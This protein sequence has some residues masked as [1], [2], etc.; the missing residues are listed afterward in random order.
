MESA[1]RRSRAWILL[2][3]GVGTFMSAL[4]SSIVNVVLPVIRAETGAGI[5]AVQWTVTTYLLAVSGAL[6]GFGR[7]GDLQGHKRVYLWGFWVFVGGSLLCGVAPTVALLAAARA[8]QGIGAAVLFANSPAIVT[9]NFPAARR[10]Q[11]LGLIA[12]ATYLGL[13]VGPPLGG[14]LADT[15]TWRAVFFINVPVGAL[16][17]AIGVHFIPD[18]PPRSTGER[19]DIAGAALFTAGLVAL[20]LGLNQAHALG[21]GSPPI[22]GLLGLAAALL[23]AFL[24]WE[25]R[26][27][28]PMLDLRLFRDRVFSASTSGALLNYVAVYTLVFL[29]PFYLIQGR[30]LSASAAGA[31]LM[32][33]PAVMAVTAP[34]AGSL[35]DRVGSR[36]LATVGMTI[37]AVGLVALATLPP[38]VSLVAVA[39]TLAVVG[40]GTGTF[41]SP[42]NSALMGAAPR[43]RQGVAAAVL[44]EARNVGMVLGVGMAGA[45]FTTFLPRTPGAA[46]YITA[47]SAAL[48]AAAAA[49]ALSAAVSAIA[50]ARGARAG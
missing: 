12:T 37:M 43:H 45:I 13:T 4:D 24:W 50:G 5:A 11:A 49:A 22:L 28:Y 9:T 34:L 21:W 15:L 25:W 36:L 10:G 1:D 40:L 17:L 47:A 6:L 38:S 48:Y 30:G 8:M 18:D 29:M 7:L 42:N 46:D 33:Q 23:A 41:I 3:V 31:L 16:A 39:A 19:F 32:V 26:D 20:L 27:D 44:A 14:W 35:S 2:A